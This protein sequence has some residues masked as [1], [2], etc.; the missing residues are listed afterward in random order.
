[1]STNTLNT[2]IQQRCDTEA[3][4]NSNNPVLLKNEVGYIPDG[5]FKIGNGTSTWSQL[6][7]NTAN[8]ALNATYASKLSTP[9]AIDGVN[10]NGE[11]PVTHYGTCSTDPDVVAKTVSL[12]NFTLVTGARVVVT[13]TQPNA[14]SNPT[15]NVNDTGA[16]PI[17]YR[18]YTIPQDCLDAYRTYEFIFDGINYNL[19]GDIDT[20]LVYSF[21]TTTQSGLLSYSTNVATTSEIQTYLGY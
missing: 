21:A 20:N 2:K 1:M 18:G 12:N 13:F 5:R 19:I 10:F 16:K 15:L 17:Y 9:R 14:V 3:N 8:T 11:A 4:W 7:Y 6:S